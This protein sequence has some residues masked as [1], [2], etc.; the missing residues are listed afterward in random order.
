MRLYFNQTRRII[1]LSLW[2]NIG[3]AE[4]KPEL[5]LFLGPVLEK[6]TPYGENV[7]EIPR[8]KILYANLFGAVP[9]PEAACSGKGTNCHTNENARGSIFIEQFSKTGVLQTPNSVAAYHKTP[10]AVSEG[11]LPIE[12]IQTAR[13]N[14]RGSIR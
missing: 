11:T 5:Q 6:V 3:Y 9:T 13:Y 14:P 2:V 7:P 1:Q 4:S 10:Y 8:N 12:P